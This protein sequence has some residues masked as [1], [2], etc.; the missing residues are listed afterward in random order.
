MQIV[1]CPNKILTTLSLFWQHSSLLYKS[2]FLC[3]FRV[4][5]EWWW[6]LPI[7]EVY[8]AK[9]LK[10]CGHPPE[11][12]NAQLFYLGHRWSYLTIAAL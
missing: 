9:F 12:N 3:L 4:D 5:K 11:K 1:L 6:F 2:L 7:I 8:T 10:G